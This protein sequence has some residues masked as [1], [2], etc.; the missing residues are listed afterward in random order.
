MRTFDLFEGIEF[1]L[2]FAAI[3]GWVATEFIQGREG[4][5]T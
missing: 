1:N 5:V 3:I 2:K 4:R